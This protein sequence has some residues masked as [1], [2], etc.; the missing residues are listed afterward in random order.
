MADVTVITPNPVQDLV[1]LAT[2]KTV[3]GIAATDT[4]QDALLSL[5]ISEA[6]SVAQNYC[7]RIF[8]LEELEERHR[9]RLY[10]DHERGSYILAL[11]RPP[12]VDLIE[13]R[14]PDDV[15]IPATAYE[16]VDAEAGL[17][18]LSAYE[19]HWWWSWWFGG[20]ITAPYKM[21]V[22]Y[23]GGYNL[24]VG[25]ATAPALPAAVGRG[26]IE[27]VKNVQTQ[28]TRASDVVSERIGDYSIRYES[29]SDLIS[30]S[31][32][33][34]SSSFGSQLTSTVQSALAPYKIWVAG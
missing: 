8:A 24:P 32:G 33:G 15:I 11:S 23:R 31:N 3:L 12:I 29:Q 22:R 4:S 9:R 7:N 1:D 19:R 28:A 34:A 20:N 16:I 17:I 5:Y 10:F 18:G 14:N 30:A 2:V 27:F 25:T 6:T 13:L 26:V 21:K